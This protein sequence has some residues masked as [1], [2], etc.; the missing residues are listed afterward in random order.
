MAIEIEPFTEGSTEPMAL[1]A[2]ETEDVELLLGNP[3]KLI[4]IGAGLTEPL[5]TG[6]VDLLRVYADIFAWESSDMP[7]VSESVAL[8]KLHTDPSRKPVIQKRRVSP[9]KDRRS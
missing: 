2:E 9:Q 6:L 3:N 8:H 5:R 1:P 7:G 4:K